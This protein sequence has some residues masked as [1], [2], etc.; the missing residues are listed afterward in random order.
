MSDYPS[1]LPARGPMRVTATQPVTMASSYGMST[2]AT[3]S[4]PLNPLDR[5]AAAGISSYTMWNR[6]S[7]LNPARSRGVGT[8]TSIQRLSASIRM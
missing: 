1:P 8:K 6:S 7:R 2:S 5:A 3:S 4:A